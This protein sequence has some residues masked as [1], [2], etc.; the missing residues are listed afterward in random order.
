MRILVVEDNVPVAGVIISAIEEAGHVVVG[1]SRSVEQSLEQLSECDC[2]VVILDVDLMGVNSAPVA[3]EL[4]SRNIPFLVVTASTQMLMPAHLEAP[5]V[6]KPF[7]VDG[8]LKAL[9]S[10][11]HRQALARMPSRR[12]ASAPQG[13]PEPSYDAQ[14]EP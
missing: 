1:H 5:I 4:K 12:P 14:G 8:L 9:L 10:M 7:R 13:S 3:E 2:D 11:Q 6:F